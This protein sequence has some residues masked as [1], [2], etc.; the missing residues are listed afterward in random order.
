MLGHAEAR[1]G[2]RSLEG[3]DLLRLDPSSQIAVRWG[4]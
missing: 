2:D 1:I 3:I 4:R